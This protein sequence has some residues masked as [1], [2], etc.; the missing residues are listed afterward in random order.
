MS[1]FTAAEVLARAEALE[2]QIR[3]PLNTDDPKWLQRWA[4]RLR[5]LAAKKE[6][7]RKHKER[8]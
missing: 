1:S 8:H 3:D 7:A 6:K 2:R 5:Q 4:D